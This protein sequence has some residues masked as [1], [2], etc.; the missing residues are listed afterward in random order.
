MAVTHDYLADYPLS[1]QPRHELPGHIELGHAIPLGGRTR[2]PSFCAPTGGG[3]SLP[4]GLRLQIAANLVRGECSLRSVGYS[5]MQKYDTPAGQLDLVA[6][7]FGDQL[8][9]PAQSFTADIASRLEWY[10][11]RLANDY[12]CLVKHDV[13][14]HR[15]TSPVEQIFLL[16]WRYLQVDERYKVTIRPQNDLTIKNDTY[17]IDFVV[18]ST[19]KNRNLAIELDGHEFHE[20]TKEQAARDRAR[21][22]NMDFDGDCAE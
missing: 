21:E 12:E 11:K 19:D 10:K 15:I 13:N 7:Q 18:S 8:G 17:T 1:V 22:R 5:V 9:L 16:E 2:G 14:K 3:E 6:Q 20:K 4:V